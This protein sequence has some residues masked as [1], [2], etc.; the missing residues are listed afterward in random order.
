[1][2]VRFTSRSRLDRIDDDK[3]CTAFFA[4]AMNGQWC[5]LVLMVLHA[6]RMMYF[7]CL[8]LSGSM[9]GEGPIV[10]K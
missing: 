2:P 3:L 7:E 6:Q 8:K 10:I 9:P 5:K 1:M 4:S